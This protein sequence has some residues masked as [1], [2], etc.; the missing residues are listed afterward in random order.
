MADGQ[1]ILSMT[2]VGMFHYSSVGPSVNDFLAQP[3]SFV[4]DSVQAFVPP[5]PKRAKSRANS[6]HNFDI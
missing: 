2:Q 1:T 3:Q 6:I 5:K 4:S